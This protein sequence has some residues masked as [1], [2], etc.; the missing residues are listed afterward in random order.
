M[1]WKRQAKDLVTIETKM[2]KYEDKD[3]EI[4][5]V[6]KFLFSQIVQTCVAQIS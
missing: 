5:F 4:F 2:I 6:F 1:A 3:Y